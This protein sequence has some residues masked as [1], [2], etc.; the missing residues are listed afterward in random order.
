LPRGSYIS[1][2]GTGF[3][4]LN[5]PAADGLR[6]L[7]AAVAAAIGG[8]NATVVY[9]GESPDETTG[10]QQ[11][12]AQVPAGISPG[13]DVQIVLTVNG[14]STQASVTVAVK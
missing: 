4:S 11:I 7:A 2:Y 10:L 12:N 14:A 3:G 8:T 6:H 13:P 5:P 1:V 9:A